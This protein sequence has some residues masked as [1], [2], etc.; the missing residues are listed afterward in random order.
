MYFYCFVFLGHFCCTIASPPSETRF[1]DFGLFNRWHFIVNI[2][3]SLV[4]NTVTY[5][6][7]CGWFLCLSLQFFKHRL[8]YEL[9]FLNVT[10]DNFNVF[11]VW[12]QQSFLFFHSS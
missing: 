5:Y 1:M 4:W 3:C 6:V 12:P 9:Y 7:L 11:T 10:S 8:L 2:I